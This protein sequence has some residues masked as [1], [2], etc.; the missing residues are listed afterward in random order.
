ME[1]EIKVGDKIRFV[2]EKQK[3]VVQASN[4]KFAICTKPFNARNTVLYCI[5]DF[6]RGIR[7]TENLIFGLGAETKED[8]DEMLERLTSGET[9]ITHRNNTPIK[10]IS[11]EKG[12]GL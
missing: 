7:G 2:E 12:L 5:L 10:I 6:D 4:N 8:C 1:I 9:E 3:Y 11:F